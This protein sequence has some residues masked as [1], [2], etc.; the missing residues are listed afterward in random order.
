MIVAMREELIK[1]GRDSGARTIGSTLRRQGEHPPS[2]RTIHRV[3]VR[4]GVI[5]PQPRKRPRSSYRRF[6]SAQPNGMWQLDGT[7]WKL[8]DGTAVCILRLLDDHSRKIMASRAAAGENSADAWQVMLTAI[9]RHGPPAALLSDGGSAFT[10]R[11]HRGGLSEFEALL[12]SRGIQPI[13]S[14]PH[15]PQTCGKKEREWSTLKRWLDARPPA[16]DLDGLQRQLDAY[17]L[18]Y[19]TD[20]PHQGIQNQ[21][22]D[23]RYEATDKAPPPNQPL[24]PPITCRHIKV[25]PN[26]VVDLGNRYR[27]HL[28]QEWAHTYVDVIRDNLDVT[29]LHH[30][31]L[32]TTLHIDQ[33]RHYQPSGRKPGPKPKPVLSDIT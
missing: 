33:S 21:T 2:D 26:G 27:A 29:V 31:T 32:I 18:M 8:A 3:L 14:S 11:R 12:R 15:H 19:N 13:V 22:P 7:E 10:T 20:R 1:N 23:E 9:D 5:E 28:G 30:D 16:D 25:A 24:P 17:D 4:A 6:E